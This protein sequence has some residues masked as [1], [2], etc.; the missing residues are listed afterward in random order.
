MCTNLL[1]I[2]ILYPKNLLYPYFTL[3]ICHHLLTLT[4]F[5]TFISFFLLEHKRIYFEKKAQ[6]FLPIQ[7]KSIVTKTVL[8]PTFLKISSFLFHRRKKCELVTPEERILLAYLHIH[9]PRKLKL[10]SFHF[11]KASSLQNSTNSK[12]VYF[13]CL[14][15]LVHFVCV[16]FYIF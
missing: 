2:W 15:Q 13:T 16:G 1:F 5:Q 8:L 6:W 9:S 3:K 7:W 4:L 14:L 11:L 12:F 10:L